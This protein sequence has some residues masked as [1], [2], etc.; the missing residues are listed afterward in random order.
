MYVLL[1]A[2]ADMRNGV[3]P[4]S[5]YTHFLTVGYERRY[6]THSFCVFIGLR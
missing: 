5:L 4:E 2:G 1:C 3:R 6:H